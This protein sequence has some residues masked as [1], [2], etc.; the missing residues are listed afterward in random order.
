MAE[1][2]SKFVSKVALGLFWENSFKD[3]HSI[4]CYIQILLRA[5]SVTT[6]GWR[7]FSQP[8]WFR[9]YIDVVLICRRSVEQF[10]SV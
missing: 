10:V 3:T 4:W 9:R 5:D 1:F 2:Y 7:W 6:D 8:L